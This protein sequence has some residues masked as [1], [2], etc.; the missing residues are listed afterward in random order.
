MKPADHKVGAPAEQQQAVLLLT[1]RIRGLLPN[2]HASEKRMFGG[3]T[4]LVNGN[5]LCCVFK[6]GLM[7]R[8]GT[9]A[10]TD[11]LSQPHVRRPSETR[12]MPGFVFVEPPGMADRRALSH[13][14][15]MARAYVDP[16][17]P[18]R[19]KTKPAPRRKATR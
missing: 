19:R 6:H 17:P 10:E 2:G 1:E 8:V 7:L 12:K 14:I 5:M 16:L 9:D 3:I 4:F 15:G 11:A 18:K 13:W